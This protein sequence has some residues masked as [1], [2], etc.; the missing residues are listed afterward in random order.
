MATVDILIP[1]YNR[2][3]ALAVTL[4]SLIAQTYKDFRVI[5]S[6]QTES[7]DTES[8]DG[9]VIAAGEVQAVLRVLRSSL[10]GV[11]DPVQTHRHLPRR[12]MAEHRQFLLDQAT[13]P[14]ALFLDDDLILES[15]VVEQMLTAIQDEECGFVGSGLI[16]L[17]FLNDVRPDQQAIEFWE[18]SVRPE[19]LHPGMP[20]WERWKLHNAAN[21]YHI[22]QN[23]AL[24]PQNTRKYRVAWVG[25]CVLYDVAKLR[26]VGGFSFWRDLPENHCGEDVLAQQRVMA[27]YGGCGILPSG[28][29]HQELETTIYDRSNNAPVMLPLAT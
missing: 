9:G 17:S 29:Y 7:R 3:A 11:S 6:D 25:G 22:Q 8:E 27:Q 21:L 1:T 18:G 12:G 16:G 28:V 24:T 20:Q 14:Y 10:G 4:T 13:A 19:S 23:L 26:S 2:P 15:Y 5:I